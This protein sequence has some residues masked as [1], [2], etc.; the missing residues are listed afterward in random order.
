MEAA[1]NIVRWREIINIRHHETIGLSVMF[2]TCPGDSNVHS[3]FLRRSNSRHSDLVDLSFCII[4][5]VEHSGDWTTFRSQIMEIITGWWF[6]T[7]LFFYILAII[8]LLDFHIF[9]DG[10]KPPTRSASVWC[11][12]WE[13][14]S[15]C[16][17]I[18]QNFRGDHCRVDPPA[19]HHACRSALSSGKRLGIENHH[20]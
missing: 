14:R 11:K 15:S 2:P 19:T 6:G 4:G 9:S 13:S 20:S 1:P 10:L 16:P 8:F 17:A 12:A 5:C 18:D 7:F 3:P